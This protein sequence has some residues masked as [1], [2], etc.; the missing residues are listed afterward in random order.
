MKKLVLISFAAAIV[1]LLTARYLLKIDAEFTALLSDDEEHHEFA[2][3]FENFTLINT[4]KNGNVESIIYSPQTY[5]DTIQ[6]I[7]TMEAPE[8]EMASD[9]S[10]PAKITADIGEVFHQS[11]ITLLQD[12]VKVSIANEQNIRMSTDELTLDHNQQLASTDLPA[13]VLYSKGQMQSTGLEFQF[14]GTKIKFL[15]NVRGI[16]EY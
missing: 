4:D 3:E 6:Q 5:L 8:I 1:M 11:N 15:N 2:H 13:T 7:T 9:Q 16:Y 12:N 10:A 14:D